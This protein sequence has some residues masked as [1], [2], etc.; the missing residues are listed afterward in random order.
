MASRLAVIGDPIE[1]SKSPLLHG[2]AYEVLGLGWSY[3]RIRVPRHR[4][5]SFVN[6]LD[7]SWRGVE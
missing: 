2:A 5:S 4:L 7:A 6:E 1:H 3:E